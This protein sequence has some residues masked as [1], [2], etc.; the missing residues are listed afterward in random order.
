MKQPARQFYT[1]EFLEKLN[2]TYRSVIS[3]QEK[4]L[5]FCHEIYCCITRFI[6][7]SF[8][9]VSFQLFERV[10]FLWQ[11]HQTTPIVT[12]IS[13]NNEKQIFEI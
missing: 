13:I 6:K 5:N 11:V 1:K 4:H 10:G 12:A 7:L 8:V 9:C 3:R 2:D